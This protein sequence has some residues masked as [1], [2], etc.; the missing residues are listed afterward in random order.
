[1]QAPPELSMRWAVCQARWANGSAL[2]SANAPLDASRRKEGTR[3]G[4][5]RPVVQ[6]RRVTASRHKDQSWG[7]TMER[8]AIELLFVEAQERPQQLIVLTAP[9][10]RQAARCNESAGRQ[11]RLEEPPDIGVSHALCGAGDEGIQILIGRGNTPPGER[12]DGV[13][14]DL[15]SHFVDARRALSADMSASNGQV[16]GLISRG[17]LVVETAPRR[18]CLLSF[19]MSRRSRSS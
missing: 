1:M 18:V 8:V 6:P 11:L 9:E 16:N 10:E 7:Q 15:P 14:I 19:A 12:S 2:R 13:Y 5:G 4:L 17:S 3:D